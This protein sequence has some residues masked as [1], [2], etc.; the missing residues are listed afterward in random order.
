MGANARQAT[1]ASVF[2]YDIEPRNNV[3]PLLQAP[4]QAISN[5]MLHRP[6]ALS[7]A[8]LVMKVKSDLNEPSLGETERRQLSLQPWRE[9][10]PTRDC[11]ILIVLKRK[12]LSPVSLI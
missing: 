5:V 2:D 7:N 6:V 11:S 4:P 3:E 9:G 8:D 1:R 12:S 10:S